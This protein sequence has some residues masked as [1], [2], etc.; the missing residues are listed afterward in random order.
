MDWQPWRLKKVEV[1]EQEKRELRVGDLVRFTRNDRE[2]GWKNGETGRVVEVNEEGLSVVV[3]IKHGI[4]QTVR[5]TL[6]LGKD[7]HWEHG[8]ASTIFSAQ[9]RTTDEVVIHRPAVRVLS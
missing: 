1:Y 6:D 7:R 4:S 9:G 8:Y 3:E 5:H 2:R